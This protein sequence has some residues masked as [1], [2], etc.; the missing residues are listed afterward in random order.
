MDNQFV[1]D[2]VKGV[3]LLCTDL[4]GFGRDYRDRSLGGVDYRVW[5]YETGI[6][7]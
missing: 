7:A 2:F 3:I 4:Q 1:W 5:G 6:M